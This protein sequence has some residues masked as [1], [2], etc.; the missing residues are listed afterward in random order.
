MLKK[1][2]LYKLGKKEGDN[3]NVIYRYI[4]GALNV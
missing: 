4:G 3:R 2:A 1:E